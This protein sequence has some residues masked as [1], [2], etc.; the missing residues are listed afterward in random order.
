MA[1][2]AQLDT[3]P[4]EPAFVAGDAPD[5]APVEARGTPAAARI[6]VVEAADP[7]SPSA[8]RRSVRP[9]AFTPLLGA[10]TAAAGLYFLLQALRQLGVKDLL[11]SSAELAATA[12]VPQ[13]LRRLAV[14]AGVAAEDPI[15]W[16]LDVAEAELPAAPAATVRL[17][18]VR[19]RRWCW[20]EGRITVRDV[21]RRPGQVWLTR[22]DLDVTLPMDQ[23]DVRIRRVGLDIDPGWLPWFGKIVRFHYRDRDPA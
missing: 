17:W 12:F 11:A 3:D 8:A 6:A 5:G 7:M 1:A 20:R 19:V 22:T 16:C 4:V 9:A 18:A 21:I 15:L 23:A 2:T 13:I 14:H 10:P